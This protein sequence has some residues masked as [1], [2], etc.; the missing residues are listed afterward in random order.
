MDPVAL[1]RGRQELLRIGAVL[2][3]V[4]AM[5]VGTDSGDWLA[6]CLWIA[7]YTVI[8]V[9]AAVVAFTDTGRAITG[10]RW[11]FVTAIID[12]IALSGFQF[13]TT[14]GYVPLLVVGLLP[15]MVILQLSWRRAAVVLL[16]SIGAFAMTVMED[17]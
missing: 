15:L 4:G 2:I 7:A 13:L 9:I 3:M 10:H 8:A 12:V 16:L 5:L 17:R 1:A 14:G 11:Q 6:Q